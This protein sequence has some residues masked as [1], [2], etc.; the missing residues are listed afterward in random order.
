MK[1]TRRDKW[2]PDVVRVTNPADPS[3]FVDVERYDDPLG[4]DTEGLAA[5]LPDDAFTMQL[6][7][8][9]TG[10]SEEEDA[11][12]F[13]AQQFDPDIGYCRNCEIQF[14]T[15]GQGLGQCPNCG[16]QLSDLSIEPI[17]YK[18]KHT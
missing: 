4:L 17:H 14:T 1:L 5:L 3:V 15:P 13:F 18:R 9:P 6:V 8:I 10:L 12:R 16:D 11:G 2:T 7:P